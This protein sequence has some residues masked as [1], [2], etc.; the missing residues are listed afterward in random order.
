MGRTGGKFLYYCRQIA[1]LTGHREYPFCISKDV[2]PIR[3][4]QPMDGKPTTLLH[5]PAYTRSAFPVIS[6]HSS[7]GIRFSGQTAYGFRVDKAAYILKIVKI[8]LYL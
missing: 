8:L 1:N 5:I 3:R 6:V 7:G 2:C 4:G